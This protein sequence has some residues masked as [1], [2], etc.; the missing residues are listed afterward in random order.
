MIINSGTSGIA[1]SANGASSLSLTTG[2]L[3][4]NGAATLAVV[5][6]ANSTL[7]IG[8][9]WTQSSGASLLIDL[10]GGA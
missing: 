2:A 7:T 6:G 9:A 4:V 10:T 5:S 1:L 8:N 3:T